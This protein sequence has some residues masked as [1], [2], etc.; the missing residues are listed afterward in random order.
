MRG[1]PCLA[2]ETT[3]RTDSIPHAVT[4]SFD[5]SQPSSVWL[6]GFYY[7]VCPYAASFQLTKMCH[8][9]SY[10][11]ATR[12]IREAGTHVGRGK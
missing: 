11:S 8:Q 5:Y 6:L 2:S 7:Y 3:S 1:L 12:R 9:A 4:L 10:V